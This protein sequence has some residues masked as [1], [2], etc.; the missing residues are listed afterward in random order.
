MN[1]CAHQKHSLW[2]FE[3]PCFYKSWKEILKYKFGV[4]TPFQ[5]SQT[6]LS[7]VKRNNPSPLS[8]MVQSLSLD[9][10]VWVKV[11][12]KSTQWCL[13]WTMR[14]FMPLN[15]LC[16]QERWIIINAN[17]EGELFEVQAMEVNYILLSVCSHSTSNNI[18][19]KM[20]QFTLHQVTKSDSVR[21]QK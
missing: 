8:D 19:F 2:L 3:T 14:L 4:F 15:N 10:F 12:F 13:T 17:L 5:K 18:H 11:F 16:S 7:S 20:L 1:H 6:T 21:E 9:N